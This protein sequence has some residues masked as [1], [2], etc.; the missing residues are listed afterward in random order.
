MFAASVIDADVPRQ[1]SVETV[2]SQTGDRQ[3]ANAASEQGV[4]MRL[5][6]LGVVGVVG[7]LLCGCSDTVQQE[8]DLDALLRTSQVK[9]PVPAVST[10]DR[11][12]ARREACSIWFRRIR[13][14]DSV[15]LRDGARIGAVH[16]FA[17]QTSL[18]AI[19]VD[20]GGGMY[21]PS[22]IEVENGNLVLSYVFGTH[23]GTDIEHLQY[24]AEVHLV[25]A[26]S[27]AR[28]VRVPFGPLS[29]Q[30]NGR[31]TYTCFSFVRMRDKIGDVQEAVL[32]VRLEY[33]YPVEEESWGAGQVMGGCSHVWMSDRGVLESATTR[34]VGS[35]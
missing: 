6:G 8:D 31:P 26:E 3:M 14:A 35:R 4:T 21:A 30:E 10:I 12:L 17:G 29:Y 23:D 2:D 24:I 11:L 25:T 1:H 27:C 32:L 22:T 33:S 9:C 19:P 5:C 20:I 15:V 13:D 7:A 16:V 18:K 34:E 28:V